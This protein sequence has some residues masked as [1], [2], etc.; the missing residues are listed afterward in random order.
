MKRLLLLSS[1]LALPA[2]AQRLDDQ[3]TAT[4]LNR[5]APVGA[6]GGFAIP[7]VP[8]DRGLFRVRVACDRDG[9][10]VRGHSRFL[11]LQ[12]NAETLV[13]PIDFGRSAPIPLRVELF[14]EDDRTELTD[15]DETVRLYTLATFPDGRQ[16]TIDGRAYGTIYISSNP[17]IATVDEDG[18]VAVTGHGRVN[19]IAVNEGIVKREDGSYAL[20]ITQ[21]SQT[22]GGQ[23]EGLIEQVA[24]TMCGGR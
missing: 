12:P 10:L 19:I 5:S 15:L 1:L 4:V 21:R 7:N 24:R 2:Q 8:V 14:A 20:I 16:L 6:T 11:T 17:R 23:N 3:C 13:G 9:R 22:A 18:V